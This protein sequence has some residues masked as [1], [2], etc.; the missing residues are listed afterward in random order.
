VTPGSHI[1]IV[2][3]KDALAQRPDFLLVLPWHFRANFIQREAKFLAR[4][5][6]MIFPLPEIDIIGPWNA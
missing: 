1:P 2:S 6:R 3:E 4:G 5:E